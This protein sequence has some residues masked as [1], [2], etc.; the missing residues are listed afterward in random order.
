MA[1]PACPIAGGR[2]PVP[3]AGGRLGAED[4][5]AGHRLGLVLAVPLSWRGF[6]ELALGL[7]FTGGNLS[8]K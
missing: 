7:A 3:G 6:L 8:P 1:G 2:Q 4:G 5:E